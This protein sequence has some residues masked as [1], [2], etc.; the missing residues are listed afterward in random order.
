[1]PVIDLRSDTVTQP[2]AA[3]RA[4]M[5]D[6]E[7]GVIVVLAVTG[8]GEGATATY[9]IVAGAGVLDGGGDE[10]EVTFV[11][12][13]CTQWQLRRSS[14]DAVTAGDAASP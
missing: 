6:A 10:V 1:M 9:T 11:D 2:T 14:A 12:G 8:G 5:L 4:A 13:R 3:M 7:V